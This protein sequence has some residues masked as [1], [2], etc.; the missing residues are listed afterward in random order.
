MSPLQYR[1]KI[2]L[3]EARRLMPA[4]GLDATSIGLD[5]GHESAPQ[6]SREYRKIFGLPPASDAARLR[7]A[8][9]LGA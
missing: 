7:A 9:T 5:V 6:F 2:R 3:Q 1:A 8:D 4:D